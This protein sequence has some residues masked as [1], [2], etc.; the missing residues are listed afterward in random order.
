MKFE[1]FYGVG[2]TTKAI[3]KAKI[4]KLISRNKTYVYLPDKVW[5]PCLASHNGDTYPVSKELVNDKSLSLEPNS[6]II[7]DD[8][9]FL[10]RESLGILIE[11]AITKNVTVYCF[12]EFKKP[13]GG[14]TRIGSDILNAATNIKEVKLNKIWQLIKT[15]LKIIFRR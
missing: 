3:S 15:V 1:V 7:I 11:K 14:F 6:T 12:C 13:D 2:K 4:N 5:K 8:A 10:S 9:Q